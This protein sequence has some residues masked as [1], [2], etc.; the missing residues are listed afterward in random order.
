MGCTSSTSFD[1]RRR[2][3]VSGMKS[4]SGCRKF[5]SMAPPGRRSI[6]AS[7]S[8]QA[9]PSPVVSAFQTRLGE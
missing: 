8:Q 2:S 5:S 7:A 3:G 9:S 6:S 4:W 1:C